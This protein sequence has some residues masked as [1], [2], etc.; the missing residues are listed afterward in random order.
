MLDV[1]ANATTFSLPLRTDYYLV[2]HP[3][4]RSSFS[5]EGKKSGVSNDDADHHLD[6]FIDSILF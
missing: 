1:L 4:Y 3:S 5:Q 2:L 6:G